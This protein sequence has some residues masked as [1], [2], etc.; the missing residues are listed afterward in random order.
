MQSSK[1]AE[2]RLDAELGTVS[3]L[4]L[5]LC[6]SPADQCRAL[7][8]AVGDTIEGREEAPGG[9]WHEARLT[10]LWLGEEAAVWRVTERSSERPAWSE[11]EE[12]ADWTLEC[13]QWRKV[14]A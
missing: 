1:P 7:G 2:V 11:P 8:L 4:A 3:S 10:L 6:G 13:R 12:C 5:S 14:S 9:Y